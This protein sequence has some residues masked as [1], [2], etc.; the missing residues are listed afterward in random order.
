MIPLI[1]P[2]ISGIFTVA[3][4]NPSAPPNPA[5]SA[6]TRRHLAAPS[7]SIVR[8]TEAPTMYWMHLLM[9]WLPELIRALLSAPA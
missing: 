7:Q 5:A 1:E 2:I 3:T 9:S 4:A 8:L 6:N